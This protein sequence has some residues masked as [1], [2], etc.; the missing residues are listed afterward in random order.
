MS[1]LGSAIDEL[2]SEDLTGVPD[3]VLSADL[4]EIE[5]QQ[6]RLSAQWLRRLAAFHRRGAAQSDGLSTASWLRTRCR[7][8]PA[9]ASERLRVSGRLTDD[10]PETAA[11]LAAGDISYAHARVLTRAID[12]VAAAAVAEA[13]PLLV[14]TAH[15]LTPAELGYAAAHWRHVISPDLAL[16]DAARLHA[17]RRLFVSA[18]L[19]GAVAIDGMLDPEGGSTVL[20]ALTP[21]AQPLPD[22]QRTPAQRRADALVELCRRTLDDGNLPAQAAERPHVT[23]TV[24][25]ATLLAQ[26]GVPAAELDWTGP[27]PGETARRLACDAGIARVVTDGPSEVLDVGRRTRTV[28]P[29]IRRALVIRDRGCVYPGCDRP[30]PWTDAHHIV[31]WADGGPTSLAN[32]ALLCRTHHRCVHEQRWTLRRD[33]TSGRYTASPPDSASP[34]AAANARAP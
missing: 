7:L 13:E 15:R 2:A 25:L 5:R 24:E 3:A 33:Q 14:D 1:G 23:V 6:A 11:A 10:L 12:G 31:H 18:T 17:R 20:A 29:A 32:L 4:V 28:P 27:V 19:S 22:D 16:A 26:P 34:P 8:A 21:L 30:P 9:A